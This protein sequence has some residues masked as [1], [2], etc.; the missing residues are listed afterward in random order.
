MAPVEVTCFYY[1]HDG[2]CLSHVDS[3]VVKPGYPR[4]LH[5]KIGEYCA[6]C[7]EDDS[8][9][10]ISIIKREPLPQAETPKKTGWLLNMIMQL[11][12]N[13]TSKVESNQIVIGNSQRIEKH[14]KGKNGYDNL[15]AKHV[16]EPSQMESTGL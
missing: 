2:Q 15:I 8:G 6:E 16:P 9:G 11:I 7:L 4:T 3:I 1:N 10:T 14:V 5:G 12:E 13:N